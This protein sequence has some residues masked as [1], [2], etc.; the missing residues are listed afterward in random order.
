MRSAGVREIG[1]AVELLELRDPRPPQVDEALI[2]V[3][4]AGVGN[5]DNIVRTG[6]WDVGSRPPM[7]LGVEAAGTIVAVGPGVAQFR[8]GDDVVTHPLPL[9]AQETW[10]EQLLAS[11]DAVARKP[12]GASWALAGSFPVPALTAEQVL[13]EAL[14]VGEDD[15]LL[16][17]GAGGLTGG[18]LVELATLRGVEVIATAGPSS[19]DRVHRLGARHVFDR[20]DVS[21]PKRARD[22]TGG[23][24]VTAAANAAP[25]GAGTAVRAVADGGRLATITSDP[26]VEERGVSIAN[27]Y[28]RP[29]AAQLAA[30]ATL[31]GNGH[32]SPW[33]VTTFALEEVG[34]GLANVVAGAVRGAAAVEPHTRGAG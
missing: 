11:V 33:A 23:H 16:V 31:L 30:L 29:D 21:W 1:G 5:W 19:F 17:H 22:T 4:A 20:H 9:L 6:S 8:V 14:E 27:V 24:G 32:L 34:A 3:E 12:T 26:P 25:G 10:A 2:A 15:T 18:L 13:A 7:A 28:V